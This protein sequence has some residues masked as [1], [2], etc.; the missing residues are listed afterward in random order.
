[1]VIGEIGVYGFHSNHDIL[2][3][4]ALVSPEVLD[5]KRRGLSFVGM[6]R[7]SQADWFVISDQALET[8]RF[9]SVGAVWADEEERA[10]LEKRCDL[11]FEVLDKNTFATPASDD[12]LSQAD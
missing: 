1:M 2:D 11:L 12:R 9:P 3:V 5:M 7:E 8:N 6:V 4:A 10:W